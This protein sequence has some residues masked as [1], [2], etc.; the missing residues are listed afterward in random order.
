MATRYFNWKLAIVLV[1]AAFVFIVAAATLHRWQKS[2]RAE[3]ALVRGQEAYAQRDWDGAADQLGRYLMVNGKDTAALISYAKAQLN[4]RPITGGNVQLAI[5]AYRGVLRDH[6]EDI[7]TA[8]RLVQVYLSRPVLS[9]SSLADARSVAE[10]HLDGQDD[11]ALRRMLADALFYETEARP[12]QKDYKPAAEQYAKVIEAYSQ[13][14]GSNKT[15]PN[16]ILAYESI[17]RIAA[18]QPESVAGIRP[19]MAGDPMKWFDEA[20][21]KNPNSA[22]AYASRAAYSLG[23]ND[24]KSAAEDLTR[25]LACDLSDASVH[26]RVIATLIGLDDRERA[27]QQLE[28]LQAVS[29]REPGLWSTWAGLV[30]KDVDKEQMRRLAEDGMK[31]LEPDVWDFMPVAVQLLILSSDT[32]KKED[33]NCELS[34]QAKIDD[35]ILQ[36]QNREIELATVAYLQGLTAE[37]RERFHEAIGHWQRTVS[38]PGATEQMLVAAYRRLAATYSRLGD[39]RSAIGQLQLLLSKDP[40]NPDDVILSQLELA[41]LYAQVKDWPKTLEEARRVRDLGE[42]HPPVV[43][44]A[45]LLGLRAQ[46]YILA[47]SGA[48]VNLPAWQ[49]LETQAMNLDKDT[50]GALAVKF[51]RVQIAFMQTKLAEADS[52][53]TELEGQHPSDLR[54]MLF[55]AQLYESQGNEAEARAKYQELIAKFPEILD[56]VQAF[57]VFLDRQNQREQCETMVKEAFARIREPQVRRD[58]GLLLAE[59]YLRWRQSEKCQQ[60]LTDMVSQFPDEIQPKRLLLAC[61]S[62]RQDEIGSQRIIDAIRKLEGEN[63]PVWRYE[64]ASLLVRGKDKDWQEALQKARDGDPARL[65]ASPVYLQVTKLLQ[66]ALSASPDDVGSRLLLADTYELAREQQLA[67]TMYREAYDRAS[68]NSQILVRLVSLLHRTGGFAEARKYLDK[69]EELDRLNPLLQRLQ[70]ENDLSHDDTESAARKLEQLLG[71]D[72]ND[73][74]LRLSYARVLIRRAEFGKAETILADLRAKLSAS[75][76]AELIPVARE[77]IR[78]YAEQRDM[79]KAVQVCNELVDELHSAIAHMLRA[80]VYLVMKENDK[81]I[82][83]LGQA[84]SLESANV[85]TWMARARVYS[86]LGRIPEA[87][88]DI[89]QA[90]TLVSEEPSAQKLSVQKLAARVFMDSGKQSLLREAEG[91]L[92]TAMANQ[93]EKKDPE[94]SVL[95]ADVLIRRDTGPARDEARTLLR[96]VTNDYPSYPDGWRLAARLELSQ[97]DLGRALDIATRGLAYNDKNKD[98]LLIKAMVEKKLSP[99]VAAMTTLPG[100][101]EAYPDDVGIVIEW[102]DAYAR[103]QRPEKAV[104]L[105]E[106]KLPNFTGT[107]RRR[108]EIALAAALY[109]NGQ[110]EK[111]HSLF[112]TLITADPNDPVPVMT[113]AGLLRKQARW[114][115]MNQLV[116][117]W[118]TTNPKDAE[119]ATSVARLLASSGDKTALQ[120]AEDQLRMILSENPE[121]VSTLVLLAMMMQDGG[122]NEE[123]TELNRQILALDPNNVIA[124]NNLAWILCEQPSPSPASL[125]EAITL[126]NRGLEILPDYMDLLDTRGVVYYRSGNADEAVKDFTKC[127]SLYPADSPQSAGVQ[128]HLARSLADLNRRSE[129]VEHLRQAIVLNRKNVPLAEQHASEGRK[130]HAMK[131]LRDALALEEEIVAL[132][133]RFSPQD[134]EGIRETDD[135]TRARLDFEQ[136]EKGR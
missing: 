82:Q 34:D 104:T 89:R 37:K 77:Q 114:T 99:S 43:L 60:W 45:T 30:M 78:L 13:K 118:R 92:E 6:P 88:S 120:M 76:L 115:E 85:G 35:Y 119:T 4:R 110:E 25:A 58:A 51:L 97:E 79:D 130:T 1:V 93:P 28:A 24:K 80:E 67:L 81:A 47:A 94:L 105:L 135:W 87:V 57:A 70:V 2:T 68:N 50:N 109:G 133:T 98:L 5:Q 22:F 19:D 61:E 44:E 39:Y 103:A 63:G 71:R 69:A 96:Q 16:E 40:R 10:R 111:A 32:V 31:A 90:L 112:D 124:I 48:N 20:V 126:A 8:K 65:L 27:K 66:E 101:A 54:L 125:Q 15:D 86:S 116:N 127:I 134:F 84:I 26:L 38:L 14:T 108:C 62:V 17:G 23:Q 113:L 91:I 117:R 41:R 64:Q 29:P 7:E 3:H 106:Q 121:S 72:P 46:A 55:R 49:D 53:L 56:P 122:R 123:A 36:M 42:K 75:E 95:K 128:F 73:F 129:A 21:S 83:D 11:P 100:L 74:G 107:S 9:F 52:L 136:L 12:G 102:A 33:G 131:V 132:K 18:I 59:F